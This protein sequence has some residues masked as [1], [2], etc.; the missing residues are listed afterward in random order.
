MSILFS[1]LCLGITFDLQGPP[2]ISL[3]EASGL[4]LYDGIHDTDGK[5]L[6][7]VYNNLTA[8]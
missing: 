2:E 1:H 8:G 5:T 3:L 7:N 4:Q 6:S